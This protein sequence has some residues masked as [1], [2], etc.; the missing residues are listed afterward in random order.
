MHG[1]WSRSNNTCGLLIVLQVQNMATK[2]GDSDDLVITAF[3]KQ[4]KQYQDLMKGLQVCICPKCF[5]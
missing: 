2:S 1:G 4:Q 5:L 3:K